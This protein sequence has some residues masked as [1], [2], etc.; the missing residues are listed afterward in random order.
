MRET[1]PAFR[2]KQR[3][4]QQF[5]RTDRKNPAGIA[6]IGNRDA[7]RLWRYLCAVI[8]LGQPQH[9]RGGYVLRAGLGRG[10]HGNSSTN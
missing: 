1:A 4:L 9:R 10:G 6:G 5:T 7:Q 8:G 3:A 2:G